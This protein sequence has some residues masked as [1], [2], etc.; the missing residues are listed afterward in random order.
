MKIGRLVRQSLAHFVKKNLT[1]AM[2]V[3]IGTAVIAGALMVGESVRY[4]LHHTVALRLGRVT[5]S[6]TAGDRFFTTDLAERMIRSTDVS[7]AP[8]MLLDG[9]A[10]ARGGEVRSEKV[11]IIGLTGAA[12][13]LF[14]INPFF[15]SIQPGEVIISSSLAEMLAVSPGESLL[16]RVQKASLIPLN[17]PFVSDKGNSVPIRATIRAVATNEQMGRFDLNQS[18]SAP[19][20]AFFRLD[21]LNN[22]MDMKER[23]NTV[24]FRTLTHSAGDLENELKSAWEPPDLSLTMA[25]RN[26]SNQLEITSERVFVDKQVSDLFQQS[27]WKAEPILTYF[28]NGMARGNEETPYSFVSTFQDPSLGSSD[29]LINSWLADDLHASVGDSLTV[30]YFIVGPLRELTEESATFHIKGIV[31]MTG[32]FAD[33]SLV[34]DLPGL[35]DAGNCSDWETGIPIDLEKIRDRDESYWEEFRGT[36]KAFVAYDRAREMWWNRFGEVTAI[37]VESGFGEIRGFLK[38]RLN[39][40]DFGFVVSPVLEQGITAASSGVDFSQLFLSLSFFLLLAGVLL[41]VLLFRLTITGRMEQI[42]T[43]SMIG[44]SRSLINRIL[45]VENLW[46]SV[47]GALIGVGLAIGYNLL[48]FKALNTIWQDV[49]RTDVLVFHLGVLPILTGFFS[50]LALSVMTLWFTIHRFLQRSG[51]ELQKQITNDAEPSRIAWRTCVI[52]FTGIIPIGLII[53]QLF[54]GETHDPMIFFTAAGLLLLS[55]MLIADQRLI[56]SSLVTDHW[57]LIT[58]HWSLKELR[59]KNA[60]RQRGRSLSILSMLAIGTFIVI[61]TGA[62]RKSFESEVGDRKGGSGG[63]LFYAESSVPVL[64]DL[65]LPEVRKE[66]G[67]SANYPVIQFMRKEGEDASCLNLNRVSQPGLLGVKPEAMHGRFRFVKGIKTINRE[68]PWSI[69]NAGQQ[70]DIIYGVADQT[71]I[72]WGLGMKVGDTLH[73]TDEMGRDLKAILAAGLAAS[74][75]QGSVLISSDQMIRHYPSISGNSV[76]LLGNSENEEDKT[77]IPDEWMLTFRDYGMVLTPSA[78]RL[79]MF[80][81]VE[82]TYLSIF[83]VMGAFGLLLGTIGLGI[84]V[85]RTMQERRHELALFRLLGFS[86]P[87]LWKMIVL[88]FSGLLVS[89]ILIGSVAAMVAILP[90]L[91]RPDTQTDPWFLL[92][93]VTVLLVNGLVW[94]GTLAGL[95]L[96]DA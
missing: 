54:S 12:D 46:V 27:A 19:L 26:G 14:G 11:R 47:V 13:T 43:L 85:V 67:L 64:K 6:L 42:G 94:I 41:T 76:F 25:P 10:V 56:R 81:S 79:A 7:A 34:P 9:M 23:A 2:G 53:W 68:D 24:L 49:V 5:H 86:R 71:V 33:A 44:Y 82:N 83:M 3:A 36:P 8:V 62:N 18:Q 74:V 22:R 29:I 78:G 59:S 4:S 15:D 16:F 90:S 38:E 77:I 66:Y 48:V 92:A 28:V 89:G 84:V 93:M 32:R 75:F 45:M 40:V 70:Q 60:G 73:Y 87:T 65:N 35:S 96:R 91:I 20:N 50:G 21:D 95:Q 1:V 61:A 39:P 58:G 72:Q 30:R 51:T 57:S 31:P 63:T 69:L 17:A 88:E 80:H 55:L 37:R 52:G